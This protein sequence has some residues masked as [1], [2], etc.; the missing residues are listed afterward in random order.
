[1]STINQTSSAS[2]GACNPEQINQYLQKIHSLGLTKNNDAL[3]EQNT[4]EWRSLQKS[5]NTAFDAL[6]KCR[7]KAVPAFLTLLSAE[8]SQTIRCSAII[9]L[10]SMGV[11]AQPSVPAL[12]ELLKD[13]DPEIPAYTARALAKIGASSVP[14]LVQA[15]ADPEVSYGV[16]YALGHTDPTTPE[17]IDVLTKLVAETN[18]ELD[19]RW[20]AAVGLD[21]NGVDMTSFFAEYA[22]PSPYEES[23]KCLKEKGNWE[24]SNVATH[25]D[26]YI[27][28]VYTKQCR[29]VSSITVPPNPRVDPKELIEEGVKRVKEIFGKQQ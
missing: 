13:A 14:A 22:L 1:M 15:L 25:R 29:R 8:H 9:A 5:L 4:V 6:R 23:I 18:R 16:A 21:R 10:G 17:I 3:P 2:A 12:I 11:D 27:F 24:S 26:I 20:M 19:V 28:D 7:E